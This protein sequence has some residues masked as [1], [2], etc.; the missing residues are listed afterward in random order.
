MVNQLP[1]LGKSS[2]ACLIQRKTD[3]DMLLPPEKEYNVK[4]H[5]FVGGSKDELFFEETDIKFLIHKSL[6]NE[7]TRDMILH[8]IVSLKVPAGTRFYPI[9]GIYIFEPEECEMASFLDGS[10]DFLWFVV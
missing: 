3:K 8:F 2:K 1:S 9:N 5:K 6:I 4:F 7:N 10:E